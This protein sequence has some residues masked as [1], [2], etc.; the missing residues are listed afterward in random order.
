MT[1]VRPSPQAGIRNRPPEHILVVALDFTT[2]DAAATTAACERLR[3]LVRAEL[4]SDLAEQNPQTPKTAPPPETGELGFADHYDRYHLTIT[5]GFSASA[6]NRLAV[7]PLEQPQDLIAIPW[8]DLGDNPAIAQNGDLVLQVCADSLYIAEHVLRRVEHE[9]ADILK[10]VW[11]VQGTQ[12]HTSR[13][14]RVNR[15]EGRALIGFRDGTSNLDPTHNP[16]DAK[17][18]FVDPAAVANYPPQTPVIAPGQV[19][20][21]GGP[22]PPSFPPGLRTPP[23]VEPDWTT[24]G[25]YMVVRASVLNLPGWDSTTLQQQE[26]TVGR[27]KYSGNALD[28]PDDDNVATAD[29][30][31]PTDPTGATT[32]LASHIRKTNPRGPDDAARRIFRR[33]YPLIIAN[34]SALQRGLV[35]ICFGRTLSTQF[36]FITRAW[37]TNPDFPAP[38]TGVD[39]LRQFEQV[40]AGGYFFIPALN[41]PHDP[42]SWHIPT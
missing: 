19:N 13:A 28:Q 17:L 40:V 24:D 34:T 5:V 9:L 31:F 8:A 21:Y 2:T 39:T 22:Q 20:P 23:T 33:G 12:R 11:C 35:F 18:V 38:G 32:P 30:G 3:A 14:G 27:W 37:T 26:Q 10:I 29:P 1:T 4:H 6:Y 16:D 25:T 36:E 15:N 7:P 42:A 41:N